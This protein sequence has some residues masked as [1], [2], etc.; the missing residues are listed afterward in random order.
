MGWAASPGSGEEERGHRG[1]DSG[2]L[3][4]VPSEH[5]VRGVVVIL[6]WRKT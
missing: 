5:S 3:A 2:P 4:A 6:S 1:S